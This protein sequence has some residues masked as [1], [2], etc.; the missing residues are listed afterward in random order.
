MRKFYMLALPL[1]MLLFFTCGCNAV[2]PNDEVR[3][4]AFNCD[5]ELFTLKLGTAEETNEI[6]LAPLLTNT[7]LEDCIIEYDSSIIEYNPATG[8]LKALN[9]GT[10]K[11]KATSG[12]KTASVEVVV[13]RAVYC[14]S[15]KS[16]TCYVELGSTAKLTPKVNASYNMGFTYDIISG[17]DILSIDADGTITPLAAG[18]AQ[19]KVVAKTAVN[20]TLDG[21]YDS[22]W[23]VMTV[24]VVEPRTTLNLEILDENMHALPYTLDNYGIKNYTL[25][26]TAD[27]SIMYI[28]KLSSDQNLSNCFFSENTT[29]NDC[30]NLIEGSKNTRLFSQLFNYS[31]FRDGYICQSF[32]ALDCGKDYMQQSVIENGLNFYHQCL[33]QRICLNVYKETTPR[34]IAITLSTRDD[35]STEY[36]LKN[37]AGQY[38]LYEDAD[39]VYVSVDINKYCLGG[40]TYTADNIEVTEIADGVLGITSGA[41]FGAGSLTIMA[42]DGSGVEIVIPFY[43]EREML[44][45]VTDADNVNLLYMERGSAVPFVANY[46]VYDG[47]GE[48]LHTQMV[49]LV[50]VDEDDNEIIVGDDK[51][52]YCDFVY[53]SFVIE[54]C[55]EGKYNFRLRSVDYG[56]LSPLITVY[57]LDEDSLSNWS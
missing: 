54:F 28:M 51:I 37:S 35:F 10:T 49:E 24:H 2:N 27:N 34:D 33:S 4:V 44:T 22:V 25:Y 17:E 47:T 41:D 11:I 40:Y 16:E 45:I 52:S 21:G 19:I 56:Y 6:A 30:Q 26:S 57:V 9:A 13:D 23:A 8:V 7:T 31:Y 18:M 14:T 1:F 48:R 55:K 53:P 32:Y 46:T 29:A 3:V 42:T 50:F 15:I 39:P 12:Q 36:E 20:R 5:T 38:Y 43:N